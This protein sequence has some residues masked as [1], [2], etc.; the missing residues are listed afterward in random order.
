VKRGNPVN[1]GSQGNYP[2]RLRF[3]QNTEEKT[4]KL[5]LTPL[6]H[7]VMLNLCMFCFVGA[8]GV[9]RR[10]KLFYSNFVRFLVL[11][12]KAFVSQVKVME[13]GLDRLLLKYCTISVFLRY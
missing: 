6:G 4:G 7:L 8:D 2:H 11:F 13:S 10:V 9:F 5:C 1:P 12:S 3:S